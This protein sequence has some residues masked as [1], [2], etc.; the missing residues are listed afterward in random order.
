MI[1]QGKRYLQQKHSED[2]MQVFR[3]LRLTAQPGEVKLYLALLKR[4]VDDLRHSKANVRADAESFLFNSN[5]DEEDLGLENVCELLDLRVEY[6]R[7]LIR[8]QVDR[9]N[10][11]NVA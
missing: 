5:P 1:R 10:K 9:R 6:A 2:I 4:A 8:L 11:E 3:R 7:K